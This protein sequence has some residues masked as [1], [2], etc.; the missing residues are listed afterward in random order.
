MKLCKAVQLKQ[1]LFL[2]EAPFS[3]QSNAQKLFRLGLQEYLGVG[4]QPSS[5]L[6]AEG[7]R[8]KC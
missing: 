8:R 2:Q 7:W 4:F 1:E 3:L 6:G 5:P